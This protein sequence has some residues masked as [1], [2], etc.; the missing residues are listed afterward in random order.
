MFMWLNIMQMQ[1]DMERVSARSTGSTG[2]PVLMTIL[3]VSVNRIHI[4]ICRVPHPLF[5]SH[6]RSAMRRGFLPYK[7]LKVDLSEWKGCQLLLYKRYGS[8]VKGVRNNEVVCLLFSR[9]DRR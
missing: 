8:C 2:F 3:M 5:T 4:N 6:N 9:C 1:Q 7:C